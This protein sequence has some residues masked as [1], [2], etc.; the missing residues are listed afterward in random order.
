M[1]QVTYGVREFQARLGDALRAV[2]RGERVVITSRRKVVAVL[3]RE[4]GELPAGDPVER[5]LRRMASE[6]RIRLGKR[7]RI[8]P[9]K[10]F[11]LQGVSDQVLA[12]RR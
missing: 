12:D 9:F 6:G 7:R 4:E 10:A 8:R 3:T 11:A 5:K 2:Q 1:K